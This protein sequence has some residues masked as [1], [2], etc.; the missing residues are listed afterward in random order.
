MLSSLSGWWPVHCLP[1][2][3]TK[4]PPDFASH[5]LRAGYLRG[6]K[7]S[8]GP[9]VCGTPRGK[10]ASRVQLCHT[11]SCSLLFNFMAEEGFENSP[12]KRLLGR[13]SHE[14]ESRNTGLNTRKPRTKAVHTIG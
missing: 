10:H 4:K 11:K 3:T 1:V 8:D 5:A 7:I 12:L 9:V 14:K 2:E 6:G 13:G